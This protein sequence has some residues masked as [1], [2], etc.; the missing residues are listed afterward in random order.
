MAYIT[1]R[2][3]VRTLPATSASW[4]DAEPAARPIGRAVLR[5]SALAAPIVGLET[6]LAVTVLAFFGLMIDSVIAGGF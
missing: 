4:A 5:P 1:A 2:D 6:A 3:R